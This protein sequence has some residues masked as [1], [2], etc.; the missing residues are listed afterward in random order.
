M[1]WEQQLS[2][3][4]NLQVEDKS[5]GENLSISISL[6]SFRSL[7]C[8]VELS[9]GTGGVPCRAGGGEGPRTLCTVGSRRGVTWDGSLPFLCVKFS[10]ILTAGPVTSDLA[11][12]HR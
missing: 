6:K 7:A 11:N 9:S 3:I 4:E 5:S 12:R 10:P 8:G 1:W 2:D